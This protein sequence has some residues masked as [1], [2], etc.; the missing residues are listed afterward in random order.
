MD[1][2]SLILNGCH[3]IFL[4]VGGNIFHS[5]MLSTHLQLISRLRTFEAVLVLALMVR[6][7]TNPLTPND[8]YRGR[9]APPTSKRYILYIYSTNIGN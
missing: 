7:R 1:P 8:P 6:V 2:P 4:E 5:V 3:A 9:I